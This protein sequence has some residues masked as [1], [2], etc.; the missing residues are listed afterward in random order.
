MPKTSDAQK[1]ATAKWIAKNKDRHNEMKAKW[2]DE[3]RA[4]V[5]TLVAAN[6]KKYYWRNKE[7]AIFRQI[8]LDP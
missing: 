3:N 8:L 4:Y 2:L 5:N 7:F 6:N 1:R